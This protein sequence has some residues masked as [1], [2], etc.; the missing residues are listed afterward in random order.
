[1]SAVDIVSIAAA[2]P[3]PE[4]EDDDGE[5]TLEELEHPRPSQQF[6]PPRPSARSPRDQVS[7]VNKSGEGEKVARERDGVRVTLGEMANVEG[8]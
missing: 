5:F 3:L 7:S 4:P 1:M 6:L 8:L 2:V